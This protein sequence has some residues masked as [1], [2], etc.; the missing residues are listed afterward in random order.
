MVIVKGSKYSWELTFPMALIRRK[1]LKQGDWIQCIPDGERMKVA[2]KNMK[3]NKHTPYKPY[4]L[5]HSEKTRYR[6][7]V[8][9]EL[10]IKQ[11]WIRGTELQFRVEGHNVYLEEKE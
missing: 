10:F 4:Q 1:R 7:T 2:M 3:F 6:S 11:G 9:R 5:R 8:P